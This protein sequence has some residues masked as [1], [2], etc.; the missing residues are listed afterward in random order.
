MKTT[1]YGINHQMNQPMRIEIHSYEPAK[2]DQGG[3]SGVLYQSRVRCGYILTEEDPGVLSFP[4]AQASGQQLPSRR[5]SFQ[6]TAK[7]VSAM[8]L[9]TGH[10]HPSTKMKLQL[11]PIDDGTRK[12]LEKDGHNPFLELI[13]KAQK[14]ITSVLKHINTK[15]GNSSVALGEPMLVP[16]SAQLETMAYERRWTLND[17][18]IST[19][20]VHAAIDSPATFRL[21]YGWFS[22]VEHRNFAAP[23]KI[24]S[25]LSTPLDCFETGGPQKGCSK[26]DSKENLAAAQKE[27]QKPVNLNEAKDEVGTEQSSC[28]RVDRLVDKLAMQN[29]HAQS[30]VRWDDSFFNLSVGGLLSEASLQG[31]VYNGNSKSNRSESGLQS[32]QLISD[33]SVGALLAEASLQGKS[34][35]PEQSN[36]SNLDLKPAAGKGLMQ[37]SIPWDDSLTTLSIGG[38]LSEASLL[39]KFNNSHLKSVPSKQAQLISDSFDAFISGQT[40]PHPHA[41]NPSSREVHSSIFDAEETCHGFPSLKFS[42]SSKDVAWSGRVSSGASNRDTGSHP[43]GFSDFP[44]INEQAGLACDPPHPKA[45]L[46]PHSLVHKEDSSLGLRG[47]KWN[48]SLGPFDLGSSNLRQACADSDNIS[49]SVSFFLTSYAADET[50]IPPLEGYKF[51]RVETDELYLAQADETDFSVIKEI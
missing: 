31:K 50:E 4:A 13:L 48:D 36:R 37:S 51:G 27:F 14:R 2:S 15:W 29:A 19:G 21:R 10:S 6:E 22:N 35:V 5:K 41:G 38:L 20:D 18:G 39:G 44:K 9:K 3:Y 24:C 30:V 25:A 7:D 23:S 17:T 40:N 43:F 11:F 8:E 16:F 33:I 47:I 32:I 26:T 28:V 42:S 1:D 45:K 49:G 12:G 46:L 34:D